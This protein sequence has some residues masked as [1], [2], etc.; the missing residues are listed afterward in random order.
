[1]SQVIIPQEKHK[2]YLRWI[3]ILSI[4]IPL[5]VAILLNPKVPKLQLGDWTKF[6]PHLNAL[7]NSA[8]SVLLLAGYY[9]AKSRK[10]EAHRKTMQTAFVLGAL[11]LVSYVLYHLT[12][13]ST[14][15]GGQGVALRTFYYVIL[16][17]HIVLSIVVVPFVL[18]AVYYA[19]S[20]QI[21]RH[22]RIVKFTY[23]VWLYV[24]VTG[25]I[26][27]LMISPYYQ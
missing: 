14:P 11:F 8:T 20:N 2:T 15:F 21:P 13:E 25:V 10:I 22:R 24:S 7:I 12:N 16:I 18:L 4:G 3:R 17:S 1:M 9:F 5:A 6:L 27:Y 23:P 19:W 26:A